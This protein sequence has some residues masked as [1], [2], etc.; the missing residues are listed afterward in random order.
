MLTIYPMYYVIIK[1]ISDPV[2]S[3]TEPVTLY[4]QGLYFGSYELIMQD[5]HL[6]LAYANT[7]FYVAA[8]TLLMVITL[9]L[10]A[11]SLVSKK[12]VGRKWVVRFLLAPMYF[13]GG[14]IPT[15][16]LINKLNIYVIRLAMI[17]PGAVG[18]MNIILT[19]TFF[20][21]I[22]ASL[23]ES[24]EIDSAN[25]YNILFEIFIPLSNPIIAVVAIYTI[26]SIW[27]S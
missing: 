8:G 14:I 20:I 15:F 11:Y 23:S 17:L 3:L 4:P 5:S 6:W 25:N 10:C 2:A 9:V 21:A 27:N 12:L 18:I 16:I 7:L 26:V 24:A 13:G 1:S 19:K 22:S